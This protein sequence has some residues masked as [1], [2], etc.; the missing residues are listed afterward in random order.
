M[1]KKSSGK[2]AVWIIAIVLVAAIVGGGTY[3]WYD[4]Q[5]KAQQQRITSLQSQVAAGAV[6]G[7]PAY[8]ELTEAGGFDFRVGIDANGGVAADDTAN[9]IIA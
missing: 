8:L 5:L 4:T 1:S 6:T 3:M 2:T 7:N 9:S